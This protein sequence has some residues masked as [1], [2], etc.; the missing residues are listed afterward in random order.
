MD[1]IPDGCR[2]LHHRTTFQDY[3]IRVFG[4]SKEYAELNVISERK[5]KAMVNTAY[6]FKNLVWHL[7]DK[8]VNDFLDN[9]GVVLRQEFTRRAC[10]EQINTR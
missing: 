9:D 4:F 10:K 1:Y 6:P 5:F 8:W 3:L 2:C 7:C